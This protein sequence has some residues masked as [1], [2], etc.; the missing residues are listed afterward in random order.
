MGFESTDQSGL[1]QKLI[2]IE[3]WAFHF[4]WLE[5]GGRWGL[6]PLTSL[7]DHQK[8]NKI[9]KWAFHFFGWRGVANGVRVH[10]PAWLIIRSEHNPK[11]SIS[12]YWLERGGR[13]VLSP[14]T[15]QADHQKLN[16]IKIWAFH[17]IGW[18]GVVDGVWVH[19]PAWPIIQSECNPK[20]SISFF[21]PE[22]GGRW[23]WSPLTSQA[24]H[25]KLNIIKKWG[26]HF[27]TEEGWR[28]GFE[29]INQPS[30]SSD[31]ERNPKTSIS[32]YWLEM[33]GGW[34]LSPLTSLP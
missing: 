17:F 1:N 14:L 30:Q 12:F 15:S 33:G 13:W 21:W 4:F 29:S 5:R 31:V 19:W 3:K 22:R 24:D 8:L 23:G 25:Q 11:R 7:A 9:Q 27:L 2:V 34:G 16:I 10:Q 6:S 28:M 18:R 32:F 20:M 26:F